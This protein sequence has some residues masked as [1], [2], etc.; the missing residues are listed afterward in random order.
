MSSDDGNQQGPYASFPQEI[1][2]L[3]NSYFVSVATAPS[4]ARTPSA[5]STPSHPTLNELEIPEEL[6]LTS[7]KQ[8]D[9]NK[10]VDL[11]E[12][13]RAC[14]RKPPTRSHHP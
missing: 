5:P 8:L 3:F 6:V 10:L 14:C 4:E 7:L 13:Q 11:M 9:E 12:F 1:A 2:T